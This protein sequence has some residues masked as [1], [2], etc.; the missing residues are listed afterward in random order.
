MKPRILQLID[1]FDEGGSERQALELTR[2][3][4][5]TGKYEVYLASLKADG[6]L[7]ANVDDLNLGEIPSYSLKSFHDRNT[8]TQLRR[9][10]HYLRKSRIDLLHTHDFYTNVFGMAAGFLA[11]VKVR[12][13]SRRE[14]GGMRRTT[15]QR[16]QR[17][18]YAFAHRIVANSESVR[19]KLIEE[20]I[21]QKRITVIHNG[22]NPERVRAPLNVSRE[23]M[24]KGSSVQGLVDVFHTAAAHL[25]KHFVTII[26]NMRHDVKDYPTFLRAAHHVS[27]AVPDV[28]FLLAGEG[29]LKE[30][31][32]Q[33]ASHL[34]IA[35]NT[36]LLGRCENIAQLLNVSEVCVLSS[37]AEGFSN[38]ILEYMAA[39]R[40]VV[41]TD[42]GGAR[43]AIIEG[44]T[45]Y[46]VPSGDDEMMAERIIS[47]LRDP[48]KSRL[49][50]E[51]G[52]R[53]V[54]EKFS[55]R[56]L[57]QNT[58]TLYE[59]LLCNPGRTGSVSDRDGSPTLKADLRL[60]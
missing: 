58:S 22:L 50:G 53:V 36:F 26:A 49:L 20:G 23:G 57:L 12:I 10:I 59:E 1:S 4:Y 35:G 30:S 18:T 34:G 15:Q 48:A 27:K 41:A 55:P 29:E 38:S 37:R 42:V 31:I 46:L 19:R 43:E 40:A 32:K 39:A 54:E 14:T 13:A 33:L 6:I 52:R 45:G 2:L 16:A 51:R 21:N 3:L 56:A 28:G 25:P 44:E 7:R 5:D 17:L 60:N 11:G 47:L 9:F 24:L 8:V